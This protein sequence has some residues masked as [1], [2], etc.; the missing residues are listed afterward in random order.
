MVFFLA[1]LN[2]FS[3]CMFLTSISDSMFSPILKVASSSMFLT[4]IEGDFRWYV[5]NDEDEL[6]VCVVVQDPPADG[7]EH[8]GRV[9]CP[10]GR[11]EG[12]HWGFQWG[13]HYTTNKMRNRV[14]VPNIINKKCASFKIL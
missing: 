3:G 10:L 1:I 8:G 11:D 14:R 6:G 7:D 9:L 12:D 13:H 4:C 2:V 5:A